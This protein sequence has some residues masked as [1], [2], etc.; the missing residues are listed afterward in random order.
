[1]RPDPHASC[2]VLDCLCGEKT[3]IFGQAEDWL[4]R[5]PVF[6]CAC[7][8]GLTFP[9]EVQARYQASLKAS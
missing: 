2:L 7:G 8:E 3:V 4:Q 1:M 5:E 6:R 9:E